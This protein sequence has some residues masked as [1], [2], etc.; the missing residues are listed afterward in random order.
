MTKLGIVV[1]RNFNLKGVDMIAVVL[2]YHSTKSTYTC[3]C[4]LEHYYP[5]S[6]NFTKPEIGNNKSVLDKVKQEQ[7]M[8][9]ERL[10][11]FK[12]RY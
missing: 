1:F 6:A 12:S 4:G 3:N 9:N 7:K 10:K 8:K 5:A 2:P 11:K